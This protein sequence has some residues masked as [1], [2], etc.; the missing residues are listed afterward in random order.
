MKQER[1]FWQLLNEIPRVTPELKPD[2]VN[3]YM[4]KKTQALERFWN[5]MSP[6]QKHVCYMY[7][8]RLRTDI[9]NINL[10]LE[11]QSFMDM[12]I[13]HDDLPNFVSRMT[14][15]E[16]YKEAYSVLGKKAPKINV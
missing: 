13:T 9:E 14:P 12:Q 16:L 10:Y 6:F 2:A 5:A 7:S 3:L 4:N 15:E 11:T 8:Y 1:I